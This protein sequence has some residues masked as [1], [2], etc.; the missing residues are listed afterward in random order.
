MRDDG[1]LMRRLIRYIALLYQIPFPRAL[2]G[3]GGAGGGGAGRERG[4]AVQHHRHLA[5]LE[6]LMQ[7]SYQLQAARQWGTEA[8]VRC[9]QIRV[10][11]SKQ[12]KHAER[13]D[14][15]IKAPRAW[16]Q[17]KRFC[18]ACAHGCNVTRITAY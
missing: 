11:A 3:R 2:L 4:G 16:L 13:I 7:P 12:R 10:H 9:T 18:H 1:G 6:G 15:G 8:T 14:S 17:C 5:L